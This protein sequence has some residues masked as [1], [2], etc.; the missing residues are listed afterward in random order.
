MSPDRTTITRAEA[1]RRRHDEEQ[2]RRDALT[3]KRVSTSKPAPAKKAERSAHGAARKPA[4][5]KG[6]KL[7]PTNR[8]SRRYDIA[9]SAPY[10]RAGFGAG[11][12]G[13]RR[14]QS[15]ALTMPQ[16]TYGPR[17]ISLLLTIAC[18]LT[19]YIMLGMDPFIVRSAEIGG[20]LRVSAEEISSVLGGMGHPSALLNPAQ[21]E[22]NILSAFPEISAAH[23]D[24][25]VP[26]GV[27]VTV[28]ERQPVAAWQQDGQ[29]V[30]VDA[31]GY[32]FPP[33]GLVEG[34]VTV[35]AA[36][37]PPVPANLN[38]SQTFG[39]RLFLTS[40]MTM[41]LQTLSP[42]VPQGAALIYDPR[43]GLGWSDPRG[44]LVY[45][46]HSNGDMQTKLQVYQSL[47]DYLAQQNITPSLISVEYP[48][49][50]FYRVEN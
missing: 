36:G 35:S 10:G 31:Q 42:Q 27:V 16:V 2:K 11:A 20:N 23:V 3:K 28:S 6:M 49:A 44:W 33:R 14:M 43:Y 37:A 30:W 9:M 45:F 46:G 39:A 50:P 19:L 17:W 21:M 38:I 12:A 48:N 41:A 26:A 1:I 15:P 29:V 13:A 32:A 47:V 8:H 4:A 22:Y 24:V 5:P 34:L 7:V 25:T 40:E 18:V